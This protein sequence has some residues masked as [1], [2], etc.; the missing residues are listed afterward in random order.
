[1]TAKTLATLQLDDVGRRVTFETNGTTVTGY[2]TDFRVETDYVTEVTMTQDPDEAAR[3]PTRKTVTVT[4]WP[5][6][7]TGLPGD[8]RVKVAR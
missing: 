2:L 1:M 3:I 5:W 8:T 4:V 7:A 6:T